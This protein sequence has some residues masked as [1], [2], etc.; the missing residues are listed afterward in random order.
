MDNL[1]STERNFNNTITYLKKNP[2][3]KTSSKK[4]I[5]KLSNKNKILKERLSIKKTKIE[6]YK[7]QATIRDAEDYYKYEEANKKIER[8]VKSIT[9]CT[10]TLQ[11]LREYPIEERDPELIDLELNLALSILDGCYKNMTCLSELL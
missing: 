11:T 8:L 1:P 6:Y 3:P 9:C 5:E 2:R 10:E 7:E 4:R